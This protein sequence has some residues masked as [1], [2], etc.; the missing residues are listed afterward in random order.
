VVAG[1]VLVFALFHWSASALG[2]DR[3]QS[4]LLIGALVVLALLVVEAVLFGQGLRPAARA[5]GFGRPR[6]AGI[7]AAAAVSVLLLSV[8]VL[9]GRWAGVGASLSPGWLTLVP[10]L[11]AQAGIAEET[12][13]RGYL[14]RHLR[15]GRSFWSAAG[16]ST[17][18]FVAVHLLLFFSMPWPVATAAVLLSAVLTVPLAHLFELGGSTIWAPA[19]LHFVIQGALKVAVVPDH[20]SVPFPLIWMAAS[21]TLP[22]L[23]LMVPRRVTQ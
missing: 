2:S 9:Y 13:F 18:P 1:V 5:L 7:L 17:I 23:V 16:L 19:L 21:G 14:F 4:G 22:M 20:G 6:P 3:G 11:F 12:L 10:G 8:V 15:E